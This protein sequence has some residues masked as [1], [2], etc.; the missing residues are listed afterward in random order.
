MKRVFHRGRK[1]LFLSICLVLTAFVVYSFSQHTSVALHFPSPL[2]H[3]FS[4]LTGNGKEK[5]NTFGK[6]LQPGDLS[7]VLAAST[8]HPSLDGAIFFNLPATF[9]AKVSVNA[10]TLLHGNATVSGNLTA[11]NIIYGLIPGQNISITAGQTPTI[12]A[13]FSGVTTFQGQSGD[14]QLAAGSGIGVNGLTISNT[15]TGSS[16]KIFKN[17]VIGGTTIAAGSNNDTFTFAAGSGISL[18]PDSGSKTVTISSNTSGSSIPTDLTPNGVIYANSS[19]TITSLPPGTS[20]YVLQSNGAGSPP[21]WVANSANNPSFAAI[22]SG[23]NIQAAMLVGSGASLDFT[24]SGTINASTLNGATFAAPGPIGSTTANSGAFTTLTTSGLITANGGITAGGGQLRLSGLGAGVVHTDSSGIV[25]SSPLNLAGGAAEITNILPVANGGTGIATLP[26]NGELL[27]GNGTNYTLTTLSGTANQID[28]TNGPGSIT[29]SLPQNINTNATATFASLNLT[30]NSNEITLGTGNTGTISLETLTGS[31]TYT[32]P[33]ASGEICLTSGNCT[34]SGGSLSGSGTTNYLAKF[35]SSSGV[36]NSSI[37]DNGSIGIGTTSPL[38]SSGLDIEINSKG[39]AAVVV[40]QNGTGPILTAS[41]SGTPRFELAGNGTIDISGYTAGILHSNSSGALTASAV[42]L[43]TADVTGILPL[44]NGGTGLNTIPTNGQLLIGNGTNYSLATLTQ[45]ANIA[46]SNGAGS[47]QIA[48]SLTPSFTSVNGLQLTANTDGFS[49]AGGTTAR[50]LTITGGDVTI[51]CGGHTLTLTANASLNQNLLTT[52]SPIFSGLTISGLTTNGGLLYTNASGILTQTA[53][54]SVNT[55]LHGGTN[56]SYS[57]VALGTDVSGI[58]PLANGGT[59]TNTIPT[60]GQLLIGNGTGYSLAN[61][62]G[63]TNQVNVANGSGTISLSLPQ[64]INTAATPTF[65]TLSLSANVN[66]LVLGTTNTGTVTLGSLTASRTYTLPDQSGTFCLTSGNCIGGG[67]GG[68]IGGSG[69]TNYLAR[70]TDSS[71]VGNADI[72]DNGSI[73]IGTTTPIG[74]FDV[75]GAP[76]GKA[77][78]IFNYTGTDQNILTASKSGTTVF[79][80]GNTGNLQFSGGTSFLNTL[81]SLATANRTYTFPDASGTVCLTTGNC[82]G[83]GGGITGSGTA[84]QLAFFTG[85]GTIASDANLYFDNTNKLLGIGTS[86]PVSKLDVEGAV[87]GKALAIFNETGDQALLTAS[88]SGITKFIITHSGNVGVG[89]TS[90]SSLFSV[91]TNVGNYSAFT[92]DNSGNTTIGPFNTANNATPAQIIMGNYQNSG[93][94]YPAWLVNS[95]GAYWMG[96][97]QA[98]TSGTSG[99]RIGPV[100]NTH[101]QWPTIGTDTAN[102]ILDGNVGVGTTTPASL[103]SVGPTSQFQVNSSGAITAATGLTSSGTITFSGLST[104]IAHLTSSGVLSSSAINLASGDVTGILPLTNGGTNATLTAVNGGI[105]YSNASALAI[106]SAGSSGQCLVS[107]GAGAPSWATCAT[108][109]SGTNYWQLN[110]NVLSPYNTTLD[111]ALGGSATGS[112]FQVF[113]LANGTIPAGNAST[114]GQ[115]TFT[116]ANEKVDLLNNASLGFY[117]SVGGNS[118]EGAN[119]ALYIA[120]NGNVGVGTTT[121][122]SLLSVG[123]SNQFQVNSSGAIAAAT[124][125]TS[126]GTITLSGLNTAGALLYTNSSGVLGDTAQGTS[127]QCLLSGGSS[128]PTWGNCTTGGGVNYWTLTG[129]TISPTNGANNLAIGQTT[130]LA[131]SALDAEVNGLGNSIAVF[132]QKGSGPILT[133]SSSGTPRFELAG[134]GTITLSGYTTGILHSNSSGALTSSAVNLANTDVTGILPLANGGTGT[135]TIP[136]NGQL[137]IGNGTGYSLANITG[138]TNQVN[139]AN[140]S[141][142]ISLSLPQNINTAATPTFSTLSLSANANELILGSGNTGTFTLGSLT[143]NRTYTL[144]DANGT[145]CLTT[146]NCANAGG[147]VTTAGGTPTQLAFFTGSQT[148][149]SDGNLYWDNTNKRL[150]LGTTTPASLLSVGPTSQFQVNSS[151]AITAATGLTS[152]GTIT[153]S[154]LSTGIAHLTSSG[155]LSSSA[156]NLA[157]GDVTG[158]LPLTNGGTNATLTAVNGGIVYSNASALAI[159]SAGSSGQCLVSGGAGAPSWATC[160]TGT[161]GTNY[162]QLNNNVLSPYNTTLDLALGGSATGSAF[163]VFGLA[164]GTI[165]AG[166]ASTSGQLSFTNAN[167]KVDLLNNASLGFYNSVGGNS[168]EGANPA[169]YIASNGNVGVGTTTP[170]SL[171]SVGASNQFQVNSSGAIAAATG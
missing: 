73:G 97:G 19:S 35:T 18:S 31:H 8:T 134:N 34:G 21:S 164:N 48:T 125:I 80:I 39:N 120:S 95:T 28:V 157:S 139:V 74:L 38:A 156:I 52:S 6:P 47:I 25:S 153:F 108:G 22:T 76:N 90:P 128:T 145:V 121:P 89:T 55:V 112:A 70:F 23:T 126:S 79:T 167:A 123:A 7:S 100:A 148:I 109:T 166:T 106:S 26:G 111:L 1:L 107:G 64:N 94:S 27:I 124:G 63:T 114:S 146:G 13:T 149:A 24:G 17:F 132:N 163:Q 15:D 30:N 66:E 140:G 33:D 41:S 92:V 93:T 168:G 158:I 45:G 50:T 11:P 143:G 116:N 53:A 96:I 127:G 99:I 40:N 9:N 82:A 3:V 102:I 56:P 84:T 88:A 42:N 10:D 87:K 67:G 118:G 4:F 104:G 37:F 160:A 136:T 46:I 69:T 137:L 16:Q 151:G 115:I 75:E 62:T 58:L 77:L 86:S 147:G 72:F 170:A 105:V 110:N 141:G 43:A 131:N 161:S 142:T 49:I 91:G 159:S 85:S 165:P 101:T 103:L 150:G 129:S 51:N 119:P 155:V 83:S 98:D 113:G 54:G 81:T 71:H 138:T 2:T 5:I 171:L 59:G 130:A 65:S 133:A 14:L 61:I 169:L 20:G 12:S 57:A 162:W 32:L 117:N 44:A 68:G 78:S 154:G 36:G 152:S 122:A 60:N 135:N 29:L 144:P